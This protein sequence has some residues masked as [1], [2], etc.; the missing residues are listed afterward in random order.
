MPLLCLL[1]KKLLNLE[2]AMWTIVLIS[3]LAII[4]LVLTAASAVV[5]QD[6]SISSRYS[7]HNGMYH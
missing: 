3:L 6:D 7:I 4:L 1:Y 5:A 2:A